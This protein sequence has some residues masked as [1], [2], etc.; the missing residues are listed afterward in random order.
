MPSFLQDRDDLKLLI[1]YETLK[2]L[3]LSMLTVFIPIAI[4][5]GSES[6]VLTGLYLLIRASTGFLSS[7]PVMLVIGKRGFRMGL[8]TSYLFL[9]PAVVSAYLLPYNPVYVALIGILY[10]LGKSFHKQSRD[11]EFA[12]GSD[13]SDRDMQAAYLMSLPNLG[14]FTGPVLGGIISGSL[15]FGLM[16]LV[17]LA[18]AA[19]S[20][21]PVLGMDLKK[22]Q[23]GLDPGTILTAEN[24]K[25][26]PIFVSRGI[27]AYA[28]VGLFSLFTYITVAGSLSSGLVRSLDTVG[29]MVMA[30]LSGRIS[31]RYSRTSIVVTGS[32]LAGVVFLLRIPVST[33]LQAFAVSLAGGLAYKLYDIPLFSSF[34]D[35][36]EKTEKRGFYAAKKT[37]NS[38]GKVLTAATFLYFTLAF[39][40]QAAF[41]SVFVLAAAST[42]VMA[43]TQKMNTRY[44]MEK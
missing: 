26:S 42:V 15:G 25:T 21:A 36:A 13:A 18:S 10:G 2:N 16:F 43:L 20:I 35:Q 23:E 17:A 11:L 39:D 9:I 29:F 14:R 8:Y 1:A 33:P 27:Q 41:T 4:Y 12:V 38:L 7:Y 19:V 5:S 32:L 30:Y 3:S 34:A 44:E 31:R 28:S 6:I 24:L 40:V 22:K 37:F